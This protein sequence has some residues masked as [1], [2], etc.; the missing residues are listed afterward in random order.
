VRFKDTWKKPEFYFLTWWN[1][2]SWV[3]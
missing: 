1:R 2:P 3:D